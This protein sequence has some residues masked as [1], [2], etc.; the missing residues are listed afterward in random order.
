MENVPPKIVPPKK[1]PRPLTTI[2]LTLGAV[3]VAATVF[4]FDPS[5][6]FFYPGCTFH[7]ITGLQCPGC[8]ATRSLHALLHGNFGL[9]LR[10]NALFIGL[11]IFFALR[12][13][14]FAVKYSREQTNRRFISESGVWILL[15]LTLLFGILRNFPAFSFLSP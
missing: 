1:F 4:V 10:D 8:G 3:A 15:A 2:F 5:K 9:A 13:G 6:N 7:K 11:L 12:G 14:W